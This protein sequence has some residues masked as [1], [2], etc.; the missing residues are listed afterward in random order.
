MLVSQMEHLLVRFRIVVS[1]EALRCYFLDTQ[2]RLY[3]AKHFHYSWLDIRSDSKDYCDLAIVGT[4][5]NGS[6]PIDLSIMTLCWLLK[7]AYSPVINIVFYSCDT[8]N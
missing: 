3:F 5:K 8:P 2:V 4:L 1:R 7:K 6:F